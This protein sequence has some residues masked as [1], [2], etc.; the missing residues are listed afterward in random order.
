MLQLPVLAGSKIPQG[1]CEK[2]TFTRC[3]CRPGGLQRTGGPK[4]RRTTGQTN[5]NYL[6]PPTR[7]AVYNFASLLGIRAPTKQQEGPEA[8]RSTC[9]AGGRCHCLLLKAVTENWTRSLAKVWELEVGG[10]CSWTSWAS[11]GCD[12]DQPAIHPSTVLLS[13]AGI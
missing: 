10:R 13:E 7:T 8:A 4:D 12:Q 2:S 6:I 5:A 11:R 1:G 3:T 9:F